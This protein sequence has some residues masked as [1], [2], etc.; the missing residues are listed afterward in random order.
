[1]PV[2]LVVGVLAD[3]A[4][5]EHDN[6]GL[7][8]VISAEHAF[9]CEHRGDALGVVLVHLAPE[10]ANEELARSGSPQKVRRK[11]RL[12]SRAAAV[13]RAKATGSWTTTGVLVDVA[14]TLSQE[15]TAATRQ[16][17]AAK[18]NARRRP[19]SKFATA[20]PFV[21]SLGPGGQ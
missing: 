17:P 9:A 4:G 11:D 15:A 19:F 1:M 7:F 20:R 13:S 2:K 14:L 12:V 18:S 21:P 5:V 8:E 3:T 16:A 6:V 10:G